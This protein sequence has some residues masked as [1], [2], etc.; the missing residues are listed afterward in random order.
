M[1]EVAIQVMF[2][3]KTEKQSLQ[4]HDF[5]KAFQ[6]EVLISVPIPRGGRN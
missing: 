4:V 1:K 6:G 3:S 5:I 2:F